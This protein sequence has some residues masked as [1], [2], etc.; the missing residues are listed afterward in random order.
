MRLCDADLLIVDSQSKMGHESRLD[1][2]GDLL[3]GA[4]RIYQHVQFFDR[5]GGADQGS[6][7]NNVFKLAD[8]V[9]YLFRR[10]VTRA[11]RRKG[12][13]QWIYPPSSLWPAPLG[14][15]YR[16][17][18]RER[19]AGACGCNIGFASRLPFRND[20]IITWIFSGCMQRE[21]FFF[22]AHSAL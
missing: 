17:L 12:G 6:Y 4:P 5:A 15:P 9:F 10:D 7:R 2:T 14:K 20:S 21:G 1:I 3:G 11:V 19:R 22:D 18:A 16:G 8:N 13:C